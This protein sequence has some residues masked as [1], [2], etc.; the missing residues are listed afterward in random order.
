MIYGDYDV[1]GI[2]AT[3]I[4]WQVLYQQGAKVLPFVPDRETDG[5]GIKADSFFRIQ[6][7][8]KTHSRCVT[9]FLYIY[10]YI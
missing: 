2:T 6:E 5:Y 1:D 10:T 7:E 4:L 8:K 9:V 3:A